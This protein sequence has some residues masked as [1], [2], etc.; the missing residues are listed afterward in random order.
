MILTAMRSERYFVTHLELSLEDAR[1]L[2]NTYNI[3]Y[4]LALE[5]LVR[6]HKIDPME[7]NRLVD[8]AL[9]LEKL[10]K[11]DPVARRLLMRI[12]RSEVCLWLLTNAYRTHGQRVVRLLGLQDFFEGIT[13][14]D[15]ARQPLICKPDPR[16]YLRA[17]ADAGITDPSRCYFV[18]DSALNTSAAS[19]M[20]WHT[21]H[22]LGSDDPE[23]EEPAADFTIRSLAQLTVCFPSLFKE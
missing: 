19:Q 3:Q 9:P 2:Q 23:P 11:P 22:I 20:G 16:S 15:Y 18:D 1:E 4:G 13:F 5:G 12:D 8:D 10:I 7:Y 21:A 17:M 14:C 6:H